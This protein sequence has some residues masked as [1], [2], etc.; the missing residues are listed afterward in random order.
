MRLEAPASSRVNAAE[1]GG[2][3]E[4]MNQLAL[5]PELP[6]TTTPREALAPM[7]QGDAHLAVLATRAPRDEHA[8]AELVRELQ[9]RVYRWALGL[10][11]DMD[12]A[13]DVVQDVFVAVYRRLNQFRADAPVAAWVYRITRHAVAQRLRRTQR[14][15]RLLAAMP[16]GDDVYRTDPGA[17]VDRERLHALV[18]EAFTELPSRQRAVFDLIDLQGHTPSEA[19]QLLRVEPGTIRTNLFKARRAVRTRVLAAIGAGD[20]T[21]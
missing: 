9:P 16:P 1:A 19:A 12:D 15:T 7:D 4:V 14:R 5:L 6:M 18:H 11:R 20:I 2:I 3:I 21:P 10:V 17:R 8:F 13:D